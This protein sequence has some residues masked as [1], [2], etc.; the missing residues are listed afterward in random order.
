M[1]ALRF[2]LR[3]LAR[4]LRAGELS[5]LTFALVVAVAAVAAVGMFTDRVAGAMERQAGDILAA[6]LVVHSRDPVNAAF[7]AEAAA[8]GL[9][10]SARWS[11]AS[12][13]VAGDASALANVNAVA[14]G[15]PLR[16]AVEVAD[17]PF[18]ARR[19][20]MDVPARGTAWL[21]V[22]LLAQLGLSVGERVQVGE[23]TLVVS[24]VLE[25]IPDAGFGFT[26]LAPTLLIHVDD[27]DAT[28]LIRPG[29]RVRYRLL[30]AGPS[31][32]I[33]AYAEWAG[34]NLRRGDELVDVRDERPQVAT[35]LDRADRFLGLAA[36]V[37]VL[38]AGV[39]VAMAARRYASRH[40]DAI[41]VIKSVGGTQGFVLAAHSLQVLV[42]GVAGSLVGVAVGWLAQFALVG[43]MRGLLSVQDLPPPGAWPAAI[44]VATGLV[45]LIGFALPPLLPLRR[46][47]PARV[48]RRDLGPPPLSGF[49]AYGAAATAVA[50]LLYV[51]TGDVT[52]TAIAGGGAVVA[53]AAFGAAAWLALSALARV[54][55]RVGVA[56]RYGLANI[57]RRRRDSV[58]QLVAFGLGLTVLLVLGI[59]RADLMERWSRALTA[60]APNHFLINIQTDERATLERVFRDAGLAPPTLYPMVRAR[61]S[62][63]G[64]T[65]IA[66]LEFEGRGRFMADREQN[67]SWAAEPQADNRVVA[68]EWWDASR[69]GEPLL[70]LEADAAERLGVTVG[71]ELTF[72]IAGESLTVT[73]VNTRTVDW[74]SFN[75]NFFMVLPPG[76]LDG[77]PAS[78]VGA[79][80]VGQ[81]SRGVFL[82]LLR[83]LPTVT[84]IDIEAVLA[85]VRSVVAQASRAVEFVFVFTLVAGFAVML[86]AIA[87]TRDERRRESA[88]LRT[89]GAARGVV[90][91]GLV[92]EF[93]VLGAVA[94]LLAAVA[95]NAIGAALASRV[96]DFPYAGSVWTWVAGVVG[97]AVMVGA[98]GVAA[99]RGV[100]D[101]PP[102]GVLQRA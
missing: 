10:T 92:A 54:R 63:I 9:S 20:A 75:P 60:D 8:R 29:S 44:A 98:L 59:V 43:L 87:A 2:A 37:A 1:K 65:P 82:D 61:L 26:S 46:V 24:Q 12:V 33:A 38:L 71:D 56:W 69:H 93:A 62:H 94:G 100:L 86:A 39:A 21:D 76:V 66:E 50:G 57:V 27:V 102:L 11:F 7:V 64:G 16:G 97:G 78:W 83:A 81:A 88:M 89:F 67:L 45:V 101:E 79:T 84:V 34:E 96:F 13:V 22:R 25:R 85:Q 18:G 80:Q 95:A 19:P 99:T 23:M 91:R 49:I 48:L 52:L 4:E 90:L 15:Y 68:G 55:G 32:A 36:I 74:D 73:V 3:S 5:V 31:D 51:H 70:S 35:A 6:D 41:A 47:P 53:A 30:V 77:L 28:G 72:D 58:A 17:E 14:A 42:V 40:L